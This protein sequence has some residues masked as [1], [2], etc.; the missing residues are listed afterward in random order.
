MSVRGLRRR[1]RR[2]DLDT[3]GCGGELGGPVDARPGAI[4]A[5]LAGA[6]A[7]DVRRLAELAERRPLGKA[8]RRALAEY[9]RAFAT[10]AAEDE[11]MRRADAVASLSDDQLRELAAQ[12][13]AD[14]ASR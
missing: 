7:C 11:R 6:L 14:G 8:D 3:R 12:L 1:V 4:L 2:V 5:D 13:L 9:A 10:L